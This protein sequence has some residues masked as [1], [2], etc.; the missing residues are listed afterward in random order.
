MKQ[1][2]HNSYEIWII[3]KVHL[4]HETDAMLPS[5]TISVGPL[6]RYPADHNEA[7]PPVVQHFLTR[8]SI[9]FFARTQV[10]RPCT[11][12]LVSRPRPKTNNEPCMVIVPIRPT[13]EATCDICTAW[14]PQLLSHVP[15]MLAC[16]W[17]KR[18]RQAVAAAV[19]CLYLLRKSRVLCI[20]SVLLSSVQS[21]IP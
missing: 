21:H 5:N 19:P 16:C 12:W 2:Y 11:Y 9:A 14:Y 4:I 6:S 1:R 20:E 3:S 7:I 8:R 15:D 18:M 17:S 13:S 10:R